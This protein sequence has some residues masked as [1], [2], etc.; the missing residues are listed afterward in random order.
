M[1]VLWDIIHIDLVRDF[2]AFHPKF[3]SFFSSICFDT[4]MAD[5][6]NSVNF[7]FYTI[8][9]GFVDFKRRG[10]YAGRGR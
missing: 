3:P 1:Y 6:F 10:S 5:Y 2:F 7:F 9:N 4:F 8:L